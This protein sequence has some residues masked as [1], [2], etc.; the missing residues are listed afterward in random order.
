MNQSMLYCGS[1]KVYKNKVFTRFR[2]IDMN[3]EELLKTDMDKIIDEAY[4]EKFQREVETLA[5]NLTVEDSPKLRET[6]NEKARECYQDL[7]DEEIDAIRD[8]IL[9]GALDDALQEASRKAPSLSTDYVEEKLGEA[10]T[11]SKILGEDVSATIEGISHA[12]YR[13][14]MKTLLAEADNYLND[15]KVVPEKAVNLLEE[16]ERVAEEGRIEFPGDTVKEIVVN[17]YSNLVGDLK[18]RGEGLSSLENYMA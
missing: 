1:K 17:G 4:R 13:N 18:E 6:L 12:N 10:L 16:A 15:G 9:L 7:S 11:Y 3:A 14:T 8:N 5:T 2:V